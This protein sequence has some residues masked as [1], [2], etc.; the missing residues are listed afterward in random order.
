MT[1]NPVENPVISFPSLSLFVTNSTDPLP[2]W[3]NTYRDNHFSLL[4]R[5]Q[6]DYAENT[7]NH[8]KL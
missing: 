2:R 4:H 5:I 8:N 3:S 7:H 1:D 6:Q